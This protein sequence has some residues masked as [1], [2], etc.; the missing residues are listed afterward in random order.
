MCSW[1]CAKHMCVNM[2]T[3]EFTTYYLL[4]P[5]FR[6]LFLKCPRGPPREPAGGPPGAPKNPPRKHIS[7]ICFSMFSRFFRFFRCFSDFCLFFLARASSPRKTPREAPTQEAPGGTQRRPQEAPQE[8]ARRKPPEGQDGPVMCM[9]C[10]AL[11]AAIPR[12]QGGPTCSQCSLKS[13]SCCLPGWALG[14]KG[15]GWRNSCK[16]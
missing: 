1:I 13:A 6:H 10:A 3:V 2:C 14:G 8:T 7:N 11:C 4:L 5:P 9:I 16:K 15:R 12:A